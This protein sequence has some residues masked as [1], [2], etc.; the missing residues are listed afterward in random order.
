MRDLARSAPILEIGPGL[1]ELL[2]C[3]RGAGFRDVEAC[4]PS[5]EVI[6]ACD[7]RGLAVHHITSIPEFLA[8]RLV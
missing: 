8:P 6:Q 5:H 7:E 4:D 3:P 2:V 1:G